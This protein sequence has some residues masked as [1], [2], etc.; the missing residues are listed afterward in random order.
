M[1]KHSVKIKKN[2]TKLDNQVTLKIKKSSSWTLD[3][4]VPI[5]DTVLPRCTATLRHCSRN[6]DALDSP[7]LTAIRRISSFKKAVADSPSAPN[8]STAIGTQ[9]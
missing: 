7:A 3:S 4:T 9:I 6:W 2:K 1:H 8:V 5:A